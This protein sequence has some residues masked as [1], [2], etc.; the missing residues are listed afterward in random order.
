MQHLIWRG[1]I[2]VGSLNN[3]RILVTFF[4][5]IDWVAEDLKSFMSPFHEFFRCENYLYLYFHYIFAIE[6]NIQMFLARPDM[7]HWHRGAMW[8]LCGQTEPSLHSFIM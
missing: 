4:H 2:I 5:I 6:L 1:H 8:G 3:K 7:T